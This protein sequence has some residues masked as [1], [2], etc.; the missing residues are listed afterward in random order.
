MRG[1]KLYAL[2]VSSFA[3]VLILLGLGVWQ[4]E[5]LEWKRGVLAN[6]ERA[7][8]SDAPV[9]TLRQ[10]EEM[11][12]RESSVDYLRVGIEGSFDNSAE[13]FLFSVLDREPGWRVIAPL[14]TREGRIVWVDRG[15]VPQALRSQDDRPGSLIAG[16]TALV[17]LQRRPRPRGYFTPANQPSDN[18]WYWPDVPALNASL[19]PRPGVEPSK[20]IVEALPSPSAPAWPKAVAPAPAAIANNHLQYAL[21]WF[22]LAALLVVMTFMLLKRPRKENSGRRTSP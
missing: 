8:S 15:F 22:A 2:L 19:G 12:E 21:T 11:I 13:R 3:G 4:L 9:L 17:G 18:I 20:Y 7:V 10:A 16:E 5:R 14:I 1:R 6:L